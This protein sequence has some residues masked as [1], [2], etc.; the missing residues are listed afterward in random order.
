MRPRIHGVRLS[1]AYSICLLYLQTR[2]TR[3]DLLKLHLT[4]RVEKKQLAQKAQ[5]DL[6]AKSRAFEVVFLLKILV[7]VISG[8]LA[9]SVIDLHLSHLLLNW[10]MGD[11]KGA[12]KTT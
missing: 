8:C 6:K 3:L 4:H 2:V 9:K 12:T 10:W 7:R 11:I 5:H 1:V